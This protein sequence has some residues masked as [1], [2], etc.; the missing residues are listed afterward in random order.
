M[1]IYIQTAR[2]EGNRECPFKKGERAGVF[3]KNRPQNSNPSCGIQG[4]SSAESRPY[5]KVFETKKRAP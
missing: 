4:V 3:P 1:K 5:R 2:E